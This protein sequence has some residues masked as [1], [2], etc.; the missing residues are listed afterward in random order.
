MKADQ[1]HPRRRDRISVDRGAGRSP[2][3]RLAALAA[4]LTIVPGLVAMTGDGCSDMGGVAGLFARPAPGVVAT[5]RSSEFVVGEPLS[6]TLRVDLS[7]YPEARRLNW[8][9]G[10]GSRS[11]GLPTSSGQT[12]VH[13]YL[14]PGTFTAKA[15]LFDSNGASLATGSTTV[16][17]PSPQPPPDGGDDDDDTNSNA[18][19]DDTMD[20]PTQPSRVRLRTNLGDIVIEMMPAAA[21]RTVANFLQYV[22]EG[23]YNGIVFH[24]VVANFVIQAGA[25]QS[26]GAGAEPRLIEIQDRDPIQSEA[27]NGF[28]N[29][30]GFLSMALRGQDANSGTDQFFINLK[31]NSSLDT[32]PPPFTVF[33]EVVDG[34]SVVD[35][36]A[37][38]PVGSATVQT[39]TGQTTTFT[40]VPVDDVTIL[41]ATRE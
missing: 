23:H 1:P 40:D 32:G 21:P 27:N 26:R 36:I 8:D 35:A 16:T 24:R 13:A 6:F 39:L 31:D 9:F 41:S 29:V 25:F 14:R 28:S 20:E 37:A 4:L 15:Y 38:V 18:S 5:A 2:R 17:V 34:L 33:A 11:V 30:R 12:I 10:D 7:N 3:G 22:D 19:P